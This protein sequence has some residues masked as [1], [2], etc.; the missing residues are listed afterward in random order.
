[1]NRPPRDPKE[2]LFTIG[3][4]G[5]SILQGVS[6]LGILLGVFWMA[7]LIGHSD[8]ESRRALVF[9]TLVVSNVCLILTNR[10]W[11][12]TII[13]MFKEPNAALWWVVGGASLMLTLVLSVPFL[14][15]LFHFSRLHLTDVLLCVAAGIVSIVWFEILK[16]LKGRWA[17]SA[18]SRS[19][20]LTEQVYPPKCHFPIT[21]EVSRDN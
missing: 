17:R 21:K 19:E 5:I 20:F 13:S 3:S 8:D 16:I 9:A 11:S 12:R 1:M 15:K 10:S 6:V 14:Q 7:R 2:R 4:L 18:S